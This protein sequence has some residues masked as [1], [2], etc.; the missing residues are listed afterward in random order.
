MDLDE[1]LSL[2]ARAREALAPFGASHEAS[3][4]ADHLRERG[5]ASADERLA[6]LEE[7][8][9]RRAKG[10]PLAYVLGQWA[11][12]NLEFEVGP[13][14][15]IPRPE[16]EELVE[17]AVM[18]VEN[19]QA[20]LRKLLEGGLK[21]GDLGAGSGCIGIGFFRALFQ[22]LDDY[23]GGADAVAAKSSLRL[24]EKSPVAID[25]CR[26]NL[27]RHAPS[28]RALDVKILE[29]SW[30]DLDE[31]GFDILLSNPPYLTPNEYDSIDASVRE[32]EPKSALVAEG[33]TEA[34]DG[35]RAYREIF[36]VA[37]RSLKPEG[38]LWF[39]LGLVQGEWI[40]DYAHSLGHWNEIQILRDIQKKPRF[41]VAR[42]DS[43][44]PS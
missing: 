36:E 38:W 9:A 21:V 17:A 4:I 19:S 12:R 25:W 3:W 29:K 30:N 1:R 35:T 11:F 43:A 6:S 15:L 13:G 32:F 44:K 41:F 10:E 33:T 20:Y 34:H 40:A 2:I 39:E 18:M 42:R 26:R 5:H 27:A 14:V 22:D 23:K 28:L 24:V 8:L 31:S 37:A 16:T 7:I